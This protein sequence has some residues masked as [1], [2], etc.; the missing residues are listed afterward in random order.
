MSE[1]KSASNNPHVRNPPAMFIAPTKDEYA[2]GKIKYKTAFTATSKRIK[3]GKAERE[4]LMS[5]P[6]K[7]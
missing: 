6:L 7:F 1:H 4:F 5:A 2:A 3:I